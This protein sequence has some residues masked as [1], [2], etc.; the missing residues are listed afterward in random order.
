M[1]NNQEL[2]CNVCRGERTFYLRSDLLW[3]CDDCEKTFG[4]NP[5]YESD[6]E[7][8][9]GFTTDNGALIYCQNCGNLT[10]LKI[11]LENGLC[12][13]CWEE[14]YKELSKIGYAYNEESGCIERNTAEDEED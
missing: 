13:V 4:T 5:D 11:V 10:A 3:Y 8:L 12:P 2:Y 7:L 6:E 14:L 9:E 1:V